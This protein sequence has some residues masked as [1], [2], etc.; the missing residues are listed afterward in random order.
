MTQDVEDFFG[1]GFH[2]QSDLL[3]RLGL[4]GFFQMGHDFELGFDDF[5][6]GFFPG[7]DARLMIRVDVDER[8]LEPDRPLV[9]RDKR[10]ELERVELGDADGDR[11]APVFM[12]GAARS[13]EESLKEIS[14]GD[15]GFD[16]FTSM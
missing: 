3:G 2:C 12:Q 7:L 5:G 4:S 9:E 11:L 13:A 6:G 10:A 15:S 8:T 14:G 1:V 16:Y